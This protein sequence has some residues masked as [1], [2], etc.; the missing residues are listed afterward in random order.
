MPIDYGQEGGQFEKLPKVGESAKEFHIKTV[1]KVEEPN[2]KFNFVKK[3]IK[4]LVDGT[5]VKVDVNQGFRWEFELTNGKKFSLSSWK[6]FYAFKEKNVQDGDLIRVSH[7][8]EGQW[9]VEVLNRGG[10][11]KAQGWEP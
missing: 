2:G 7:P 8:A 10:Q 6:P 4:E 5:K 1:K 9:K 3:E 11:N